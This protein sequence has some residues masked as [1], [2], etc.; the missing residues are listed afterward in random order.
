MESNRNI[1][2]E[3]KLQIES[4]STMPS[5]DVEQQRYCGDKFESLLEA[6]NKNHLELSTSFQ[7]QA[8]ILERV[9]KQT[10][11]TN[12]RVTSLEGH[13]SYLLGA[14]AAIT[15]TMGIL[16]YIGVRLVERVD[17]NAILVHKLE[18]LHKSQLEGFG[19]EQPIK[20]Q[21]F[22]EGNAE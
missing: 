13:R 10:V 4:E 17:D 8:A 22:K 12:G 19:R 21:P 15:L 5:C 3:L 1:V 2:G 20:E 9:E 7:V 18:Q 14:I 16:G 6:I 11:K